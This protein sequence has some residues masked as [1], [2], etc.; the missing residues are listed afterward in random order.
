[1]RVSGASWSWEGEVWCVCEGRKENLKVSQDAENSA[2]LG[3]R[4]WEKRRGE[5]LVLEG[6]VLRVRLTPVIGGHSR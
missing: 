1:M 2:G 3:E 6:Q 5:G 4:S